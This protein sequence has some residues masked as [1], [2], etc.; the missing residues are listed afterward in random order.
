MQNQGV[1]KTMLFLKAVGKNPPLPLPSFW[2]LLVVLD[3]LWLI[4][5]SLWSLPPQSY[6]VLPVYLCVQILMITI[7][8][9]NP[10]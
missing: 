6:G 7:I 9:S 1:R 8:E 5:K 3:I 10:L 4:T 2:W